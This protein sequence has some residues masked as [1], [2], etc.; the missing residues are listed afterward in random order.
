LGVQFNQYYAKKFIHR[1]EINKPW[2]EL[3]IKPFNGLFSYYK[4]SL[5]YY[6]KTVFKLLFCKL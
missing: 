5:C 3:L 6:L 2:S 4:L 1:K